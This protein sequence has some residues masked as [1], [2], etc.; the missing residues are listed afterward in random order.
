M[1]L[2]EGWL[3]TVAYIVLVFVFLRRIPSGNLRGRWVLGAL[4]YVFLRS[5]FVTFDPVKLLALLLYMVSLTELQI[6]PREIGVR[7]EK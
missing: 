2:R 1:A 7:C 4:T 5:L 3:V 6:G